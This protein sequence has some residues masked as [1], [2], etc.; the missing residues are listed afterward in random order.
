MPEL[1]SLPSHAAD[2]LKQRGLG[3]EVIKSN[4]I[5]WDERGKRIAI[6]IRDVDGNTKFHKYRRDPK[7]VDG[8]KY[9]YDTGST[10]A[11]FGIQYLQ[12]ARNVIIAEGELDALL[13]QSRGFFSVSST[14]GAGTWDKEWSDLLKD[15]E[16][17][18]CFDLDDAGIKG[19]F[20]VARYLP[21]AKIILLPEKIGKAGDVTDYFSK[22]GKSNEDF[23]ALME[24]GTSYY[25][26]VRVVELDD[27]P[28]NI[29]KLV[30]KI[31]K[32]AD[33]VM[34]NK[35]DLANA[36]QYFRHLEILCEIYKLAKEEYEKHIGRL[37]FKGVHPQDGGRD[38]EL[39]KTVS[40]EEFINFNAQL[41]APC[42]WH[43]ERTASMHLW[44]VQN[45]VKCFG[46]GKSGDVIDVV[47]KVFNLN[48]GEALN[49]IL[50]GD[51]QGKV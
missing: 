38:I 20:N 24:T 18:I 37:T 22:M 8:P 6:P 36:G 30:A 11:L 35:R 2:W 3:P 25:V 33:V 39:A 46:C 32:E 51:K 15:K 31:M 41:F 14:G 12:Y 34:K 4:G 40:I 23:R 10:R 13:L 42:I 28:K 43:E 17:F 48:F 9:T 29:K 16:V 27:D 44:K 5:A 21:G 50:Y 47:Q 19:A 45:K 26:P 49:H 1:K 7:S